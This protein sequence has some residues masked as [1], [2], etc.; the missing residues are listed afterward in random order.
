MSRGSEKTPSFITVLVTTGFVVDTLNS[1]A[2]CTFWVEV[3]VT[4]RPRVASYVQFASDE[5]QF[6]PFARHTEYPP[7]ESREVEVKPVML[8]FV[9]V[10]FAQTRGPVTFSADPVAFVKFRVVTVEEPA[11]KFPVSARVVPVAFVQ[12]TLVEIRLVRPR[13]VPV[14]FVQTRGPVTFRA[15]PVAFVKFRVVTVEEPAEKFPVSARGVPVAV[16][17]ASL[18]DRGGARARGAPGG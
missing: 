10:A 3:V 1:P 12:T 18:G 6:V 14:A 8:R 16:V 5:E 13:A 4:R 9:P 15:D 17:Q 11:E 2:I 7:T